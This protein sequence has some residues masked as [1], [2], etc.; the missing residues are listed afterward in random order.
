KSSKNQRLQVELALL[1]MCHLASAILLSQQGISTPSATTE[2]KKKRP[3]PA[4]I[5]RPTAVT[6]PIPTPK[7]SPAVPQASTP[8][9]VPATVSAPTVEK[10]TEAD[11]NKPVK[12]GWG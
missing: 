5:N 6:N 4:I 1:K 8:V 11:T 3:D 9:Q 7:P 12:K 10:P 2:V